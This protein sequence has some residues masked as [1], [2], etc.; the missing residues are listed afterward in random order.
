MNTYNDVKHGT[1][2][3]EDNFLSDFLKHPKEILC[4]HSHRKK[5]GKMM[6]NGRN[7]NFT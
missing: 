5:K 2:K 3:T 1:C 7:L 6:V 4:I